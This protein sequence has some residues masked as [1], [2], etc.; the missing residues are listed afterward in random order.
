M[1]RRARVRSADV[2]STHGGARRRRAR[3]TRGTAFL[4]L[5]LLVAAGL[6]LAVP[7]ALSNSGPATISS[8]QADY[9]PG[10]TVTLTGS[11][12][13]PGEAVHISVNDNVGQ[14]WSYS[15]DV[16]A[17][18]GG[19]YTNQFQLPTAFVASY[20]VTAT[21][22]LSGTA[23]TTFTD[24]AANLDQCTNGGVGDTPEPCADNA[25]FSNWVNGD[26]NGS[27]S[28][29]AED[30]FMPYRAAIKGITAGP[31]TLAIGYDTVHGGGHAIDYLGSFDATETT[32]AT[33]TVLHANNNDPCGDVL[34]GS[35]ASECTPTSPTSSLPIPDPDL[36]NCGGSLGTAPS[37][38]SGND[39]GRNMNIW[40]P[41]A[42]TIT[43]MSY[44]RQ[45]D[46][47][48]QGQCSATVKVSFTIGGTAATNTVVLAWGG[49][50]ARGA[51][52]NGWGAGDGASNVSGSPYHMSLDNSNV[53]G[54]D[55]GLDG[56]SQG[57]QD[58]ALAAKPPSGAI[59]P[60]S[61]ITIIKNTVG[62]DGT[63]GY[64]TTGGGGL[65]PS[66]DI[67]T[68]GGTGQVQND[69]INP[70]S[71]TIDESTMP[72]DW[73]FVSPL[74]CSVTGGATAGPDTP[75]GTQTDITI[76]I[77]GGASATC[78]YTNTLAAQVKVV[79]SL[80]PTGDAGKF[81]LRVNGVDKATDVGDA[82]TT[83]FISVAAG[84][85]PTVGEVAGTN[86]SLTDYVSSIACTGDS[87]ASGSGTSLS[88]GTLNAAQSATCT[89]TNHRKPQ[90]KVVKTF[91]GDTSG[92]VDLKIDTNTYD[93]S[94]AGF[95]T[96]TVG[97][98]FQNVATG[99]HT[100]SELAH[101]GT[102]LGN[103]EKAIS[104][105]N[106]KGS[107][108]GSASLQTNA[109]GYGDKVT[110]TITNTRKGKA[111]VIKTVNGAAPS[112]TQTFPFTLRQGA[113]TISTG[114][115]LETASA[116]AGNGGIIDFTTG[117]VPGN[118]YQLCEDVMPGWNTT[119]G[120]N[121]F[122]P[123]SMTTPTLPNPNVNN[124]TV[125]TDFVASAGV[126]T[127]FAVDNSPPP[128]G[129]ALTIGF[130]K[131]WASCTTSSTNKKPMLD[132]TLAIATTPLN[133]GLVV[134][135]QTAGSGWPTFG[136]AYYLVLRGDPSTLVT[137]NNAPDCSKA[138]NLL[139]KSTKTRG[140][141]MASDPLFNMTAQLI[142]A[143]LNY[144]AGA[145]GNAPTTNNILS[146]VLLDGKY[147][148]DGDTYTPKLSSSDTTKANCLATQ[149][150]NYNNDRLV[151][152]C[153]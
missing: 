6:L 101:S 80:D 36:E 112:G 49:H 39:S 130:W 116:T 56:A 29:W 58:R 30:E 88:V 69:G 37:L 27:K 145:G 47:Q 147:K 59:I 134:S 108:S 135:A 7:S 97:S 65:P 4:G 8:D 70:G 9:A 10:S 51:G 104:C 61:R 146:A 119:L 140:A 117:L 133:I 86:T 22:L 148:F 13:Q 100:V 20:L 78:I 114:T 138:V 68:S 79:K 85:N 66:F 91:V 96:T 113:N 99:T 33:S 122:V 32:S 106:S 149:L 55:K 35:L 45:N 151:S 15:A 115:T 107:N 152:T 50:I 153:P 125:C 95:G 77:A 5:L 40:G 105:D 23:T 102:D 67:L 28:H 110:C 60:S 18:A 42:T 98:D 129:R 93:N 24:S 31:H 150:D 73:S 103:Y 121:L 139:N 90:L 25:T 57:A 123:G 141:K 41:A 26:A 144:Y 19:G 124:M 46:D 136:P 74:S 44:L 17:D 120:P 43:A 89:I 53:L 111:K 131:N 126:T 11:N 109:L 137:T 142:G 21:G 52:F 82:G 71:Y 81:N 14:T 83:G 2:L 1:R 76:P 16:S 12:W 72:A 34:T 84:S 62:G 127:T 132:Q 63:F 143:Q 75:G 48:G 87:T 38:I 64:T 92:R 94:G 3:A 54:G 118:H 128:G